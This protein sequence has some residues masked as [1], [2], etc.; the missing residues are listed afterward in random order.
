MLHLALVTLA[1]TTA[2][3]GGCASS[4][5]GAGEY[6]EYTPGLNDKAMTS[7]AKMSAAEQAMIPQW[8]KGREVFRSL[9][10]A[11]CH[12]PSITLDRAVYE[13]PSRAG[14]RGL[15]I[16]LEKEGAEPRIQRARAPE[17]GFEVWLF[18]DLKRHDMGPRLAEARPDRGVPGETDL[19]RVFELASALEDQQEDEI[20]SLD[21]YLV[22]RGDP[23]RF[24]GAPEWY[25]PD[26]D[27]V[28]REIEEGSVT[29]VAVYLAMLEAPVILPPKSPALLDRWA[30][31]SALFDRIGCA[32]CHVRSL[33]L[34]DPVWREGSETTSGPPIVINLLGDGDAPRGTDEVM[35]FSDLKRHAMGEDLA[36][37]RGSPEGI[38]KG[39]F[40]TRPL[41][42]LAE[43]APYLHDGRAATIPEA[44]L[45]HGGEGKAARDAFAALPTDDQRNL[46]VFL[47]SLARAAKVRIA[48]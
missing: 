36:D 40:L 3:A 5:V 41:W 15:S 1:A 7:D 35:L 8:S 4:D 33:H 46:H 48:L 27:G 31:G 20:I 24:G 6:E 14:G 9:G 26:G 38:S 44:I 42:G 37:R 16:D 32:G 25:N 18:S 22:D 34:D 29:A 39:A 21:Q 10:C 28:S 17:G 2:I 47:L 11:G 23:L 19:D 45:A 30:Q 12:V 43:S 13:L